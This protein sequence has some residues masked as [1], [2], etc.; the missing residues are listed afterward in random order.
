MK[1]QVRPT[2]YLAQPGLAP[3]TPVSQDAAVHGTGE[4]PDCPELAQRASLLVLVSVSRWGRVVE[5]C[6]RHTGEWHFLPY[7]VSPGYTHTQGWVCLRNSGGSVQSH[8]PQSVCVCE[9][10]C[11]CLSVSLSHPNCWTS[12]RPHLSACRPHHIFCQT[13]CPFCHR[14]SCSYEVFIE[15]FFLQARRQALLPSSSAIHALLL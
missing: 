7:F 10:G 2:C 12:L 4:L 5:Q 8:P 6:L 9:C 3:C 1:K 13:I 15:L 11:A 14:S